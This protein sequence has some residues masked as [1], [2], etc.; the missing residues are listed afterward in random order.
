ML[1]YTKL[2]KEDFDKLI[3][4]ILIKFETFVDRPY[5]DNDGNIAIGYGFDLTMHTNKTIDETAKTI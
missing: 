2:T 3:R 1:S 4:D 5:H